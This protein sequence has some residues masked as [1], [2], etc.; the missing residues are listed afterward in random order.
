M[1]FREDHIEFT[2]IETLKSLGWQYL[3]AAA[4]APDGSAPQRASF[5]DAILLPRLER[6]VAKINPHLPKDTLE[7][8]LRQVLTAG[9]PNLIEENRR[10][11]RLITE[12]IGIEFRRPDGR[13]TSDG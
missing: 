2:G 8:A 7:D 10:M 4:I 13:M 1:S 6:A 9:F 12:G 3:P 11:H 5:H